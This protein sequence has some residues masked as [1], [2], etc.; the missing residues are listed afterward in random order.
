[1][2]NSIN[3]TLFILS[4]ALSPVF[5]QGAKIL[6]PENAD[7][8]IAYFHQFADSPNGEHVAY[9]MFDPPERMLVVVQT[10]STGKITPVAMVKGQNRHTGAHPLWVDDS[11]L[12]YCSDGDYKIYHHN[13]K[14]GNVVE[15][16]GGHIS[17]YSPLHQRVL[18]KNNDPAKEE[19]GIYSIDLAN[20]SKR[21]L[22]SMDDMAR[23]KVQ[24]GA[25][26]PLEH[27]RLDHPYWSP[28]GSKI[29]FQAK[30]YSGK[31]DAQAV[32]LFYTDPEASKINYV[33]IRPMHVQ[34]WDNE[35]YFGHDNHE[36]D[37]KHLRRWDLNGKLIEEL[38]G[39]GCH[40]TV[41]PDRQWIVTESWYRS[42]PII[43]NLYKRGKTK[44]TKELF[45]QPAVVRG[46]VFW[47]IRSHIH[48]AFSRDGK[49]VYFNAKGE[50]GKSKVWVFDLSD[51]I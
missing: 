16:V 19:K 28:D 50:D 27:W 21:Q 47:D 10:L 42:D 35:S 5:G 36:K 46:K 49:R 26:N 22:I 25:R 41:S 3:L 9:T 14:T 2:K 1:M 45:R 18:Y 33:G 8:V 11:S 17:D 43:V 15:Y 38:S 51:K 24:I 23:M 6:S 44:P 7:A 31:A 4:A 30:T 12:I 20:R 40:A 37:D 48:P 39:P 34:W 29:M 32:F 13:L